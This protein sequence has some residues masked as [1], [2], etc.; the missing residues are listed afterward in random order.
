LAPARGRGSEKRR[1]G[2]SGEP[3]KGTHGRGGLGRFRPAEPLLELIAQLVLV[4]RRDVAMTGEA[5]R[6]RDGLERGHGRP[7]SRPL[8]SAPA[9]VDAEDLTGDPGR[10]I[11]DEEQDGVRDVL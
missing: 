4:F 7:R 8:R 6:E 10:E 1:V 9:T 5:D 2:P 3:E 11:A